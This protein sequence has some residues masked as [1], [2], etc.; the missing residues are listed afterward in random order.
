MRASAQRAGDVVP[1]EM[2]QREE[3]QAQGRTGETEKRRTPGP[4][5]LRNEN[6]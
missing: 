4:F 5:I 3:S 2:V 1:R 6:A